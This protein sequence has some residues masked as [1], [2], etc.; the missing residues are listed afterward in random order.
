MQP[1]HQ[2]VRQEGT[3]VFFNST[4]GV[5]LLKIR[6]PEI[7]IRGYVSLREG[8]GG[9]PHDVDVAVGEDFYKRMNTYAEKRGYCRI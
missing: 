9:D 7:Y 5:F 6:C 8:E 4:R 3:S 2:P 1:E